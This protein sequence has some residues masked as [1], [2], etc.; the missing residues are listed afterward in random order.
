[1]AKSTRMIPDNV[2]VAE[3]LEE[4]A[5]SLPPGEIEEA[6]I[7]RQAANRF[8]Q[9]TTR[10]LV[11]VHEDKEDVNQVAARIVKEATEE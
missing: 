7:L 2:F 3:S 10:R 1:M 6:N 11:Y 4:L 8:R 9:H 5:D